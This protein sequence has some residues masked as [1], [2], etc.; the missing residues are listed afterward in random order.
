MDAAMFLKLF[1]KLG[2]IIEARSGRQ[3]SLFSGG[4]SIWIE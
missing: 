3:G 1:E 2:N 4:G